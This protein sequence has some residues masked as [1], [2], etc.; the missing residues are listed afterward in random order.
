MEFNTYSILVPSHDNNQCLIYTHKLT[1]NYSYFYF[2]IHKQFLILHKQNLYHKCANHMN[3]NY[4]YI[5]TLSVKAKL[6]LPDIFIRP[7]H[8][9]ISL[10]L[11]LSMT[12]C[13]NLLRNLGYSLLQTAL[14]TE[15][16]AQP[17]GLTTEQYVI[18]AKIN[19]F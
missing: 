3:S 8:Q 16:G 13:V 2:I 10:D 19:C 7:D 12:Y 18:L 15:A 4:M 5:N 6:K 11:V 14:S 9:R 1:V 17:P